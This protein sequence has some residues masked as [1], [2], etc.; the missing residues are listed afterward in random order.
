MIQQHLLISLYMGV[1]LMWSSVSVV[2]QMS[3]QTTYEWITENVIMLNKITLTISMYHNLPNYKHTCSI[4]IK[5]LLLLLLLS[6]LRDR[7][8][9]DQQRR[10]NPVQKCFLYYPKGTLVNRQDKFNNKIISVL[11][12]IKPLAGWINVS[13]LEALY[14]RIW[15]FVSIFSLN[16]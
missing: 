16:K 3:R 12:G 7:A 2:Q 5:Y 11:S 9:K 6:S 4:T 1:P 15:K 13:C 14:H 10:V 8:Q